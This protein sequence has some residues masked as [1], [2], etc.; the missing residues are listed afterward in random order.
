MT[1]NPFTKP[2]RSKPWIDDIERK[3]KQSLSIKTALTDETLSKCNSQWQS[4]LYQLPKEIRDLIFLFAST[5]SPDPRHQYKP[6]AYYYRPGHTARLKTH[7]S[8]LLTCRRIWLEANHL[9]MQQA[10]HAFWL[11][12]GY[13]DVEADKRWPLNVRREQH[14]YQNT[15]R[16]MTKA[17]LSNLNYVHLFV[18][19][20]QAEQFLHDFIWDTFFPHDQVSRGFKPK[21]FHVTIRH[22]S[23][24]KVD[25]VRGI[26]TLSTY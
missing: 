11:Q 24:L 18:Q 9:P 8:L 10:E 16:S 7:T 2:R 20:F 25:T 15:L 4:P 3:T 26:M 6:T 17:N 12:R 5:Q 1:W 23:V 13:Y 22:R 21:L 19:M 14:R